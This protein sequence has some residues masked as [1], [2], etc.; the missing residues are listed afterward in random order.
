MKTRSPAV[1]RRQFLSATSLAVAATKFAP[2][3]I[4]AA[5]T[6]T[7]PRIDCQS[8][9][10]CPEIVALME[11][12]KTDPLVYTKDGVR[13]V[14]MGDW[15]RKIPPHYLDVDAKLATMDARSPRSSGRVR[16]H[17][18]ISFSNVEVARAAKGGRPAKRSKSD[19]RHGRLVSVARCDHAMR[20]PNKTDDGRAGP[21]TSA[22]LLRSSRIRPASRPASVFLATRIVISTP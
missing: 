12:R 6:R 11:Q 4:A 20:I 15:L 14:Q 9:L 19:G 3:E 21:I 10:F 22:K 17:A 18:A 8:H 7:P 16:A 13:Y 1:S 2:A 5:A